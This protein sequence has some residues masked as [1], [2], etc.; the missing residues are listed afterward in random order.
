MDLNRQ[1]TGVEKRL[2][3]LASS[4]VQENN[5]ELYDCDYIAGSST[6]RVFIM[7]PETKSAVIDDCVL[8]DRAFTPYCE[9]DWVPE[10]FVLEVSSPG[11][12]RSL[13]TQKH[14]EISLNEIISC[15]IL[16]EL[17]EEQQGKLK[18]SDKKAKKFRGKLLAVKEEEIVLDINGAELDLK[19]AQIKKANLDPDF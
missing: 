14:F 7:N 15:V 11:V 12:Y 8:I 18:K 19:F 16:G 6:L 4:I 1:R 2:F 9:E 5:L 3:E 10:D 17:S 13:K